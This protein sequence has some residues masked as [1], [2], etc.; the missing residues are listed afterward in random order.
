[1][2]LIAS[3]P[4]GATY[5]GDGYEAQTYPDSQNLFTL[6]RAAI[7]PAGSWEISGFNEQADFEMGAF[8]PPV[9]NAGDDT[10]Y[11]S[12]HTDIGIGM[13]A[14]SP[15]ADAPRTFLNWVG[16]PGIRLALRQCAA[17]LLPAVEPLRV[18]DGRSAGE[19]IR[20]PG[21]VS[22]NPRSAPP[23]RSCRAARP[24]SRT[25]PGARLSP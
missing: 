20:D 2:H 25:R 24:T 21:A 9:Q 19:G 5:L 17:G 12:D 15:N 7:Y 6:G 14:A 4:N 23:T 13:N 11:I 16:S 8:K 10:C 18:E 3:W 1:M 22:V